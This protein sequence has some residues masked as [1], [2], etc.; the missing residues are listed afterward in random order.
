MMPIFCIVTEYVKESH[1]HMHIPHMNR[2]HFLHFVAHSRPN[3]K[4]IAFP[5]SIYAS[6][7]PQKYRQ[8]YF[9]NV[10]KTSLSISSHIWM[11]IYSLLL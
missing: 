11:R 1:T 5:D 3:F 6:Y 8:V 7:E 2:Q 4:P 9:N 10:G